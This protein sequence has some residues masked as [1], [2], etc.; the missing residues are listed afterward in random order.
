MARWI[1]G[2]LVALAFV[3]SVYLTATQLMFEA[4]QDKTADEWCKAHNLAT[5]N[6]LRAR[7]IC[8]DPKTRVA[9]I[10]E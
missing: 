1:V 7:D 4:G 8:M 9:I 2:G 3:I 6:Q 5:Y 10:P